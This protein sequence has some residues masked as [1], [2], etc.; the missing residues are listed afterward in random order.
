MR[1]RERVHEREKRDKMKKQ[2]KLDEYLKKKE[3]KEKA[4][5]EK[6]ELEFEE[7]M[8]QYAEFKKV[9]DESKVKFDIDVN[10]HKEPDSPSFEEM[11]KV[12]QEQRK[13]DEEEMLQ[14]YS[15]L[16]VDEKK[17]EQVVKRIKLKKKHEK[18]KKAR[19]E[20]DEMVIEDSEEF[21][22]RMAGKTGLPSFFFSNLVTQNRNSFAKAE[23]RNRMN[24][25]KF[26][27]KPKH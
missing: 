16:E 15:K 5:N 18:A 10:K 9:E 8:K 20:E 22:P 25:K 23:A 27:P 4:E 26:S 17:V 21:K 14:N 19:M 3:E 7:K 2:G 1:H 13:A 11:M 24:F 12:Y 6:K